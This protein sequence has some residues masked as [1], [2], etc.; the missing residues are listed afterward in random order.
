[1]RILLPALVAATA[2]AAGPAL[3]QEI[4][5]KD[6][7]RVV[8]TATLEEL[9]KQ[10]PQQKIKIWDHNEQ[11]EITFTAFPAAAFFDS[12]YGDKWRKA[13]ELLFTCVDGYQPSIP[14]AR[15]GQYA[16]YFAFGREGATA[17]TLINNTEKGRLAQLSP[18]YLIWDT[19]RAPEIKQS[20][21]VSWPYQL[22]AF[23]LIQFADRF[24]PLAPPKGASVQAQRGFVEF[25]QHCMACHSINGSGGKGGPELNYP[26]NVTEYYNPK[27]LKKWI[28][29]PTSVRYSSPMP[30]FKGLKDSDAVIDAIISYLK[31]MSEKKRAPASAHANGIEH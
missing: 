31:A 9:K 5:F 23:D 20:E 2:A 30:A 21:V 14:L 24:A 7:G 27:F 25:R 22:K 26:M 3:A 15:F 29:Q 13:E 17:F 16:A 11:T 1:M 10:V 6:H 18:L 8:R 4:T 28:G 19:I 12:V